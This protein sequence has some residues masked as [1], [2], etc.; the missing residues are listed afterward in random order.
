MTPSP[1]DWSAAISSAPLATMRHAYGLGVVYARSGGWC[2]GQYDPGC[3]WTN[4]YAEYLEEPCSVHH[5]LDKY[6]EYAKKC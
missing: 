5:I 1:G 2:T 4:E 6:A 3:C